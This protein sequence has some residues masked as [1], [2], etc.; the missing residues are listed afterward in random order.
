MP[1]TEILQKNADLR[2]L[3]KELMMIQITNG[4]QKNHTNLVEN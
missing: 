4:I 3:M 1:I 2:L